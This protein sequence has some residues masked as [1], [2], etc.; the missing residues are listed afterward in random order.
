MSETSTP[1]RPRDKATLHGVHG[2]MV[3]NGRV[4]LT[5]DLPVSGRASQL[6]LRFRSSAGKKLLREA[7]AEASPCH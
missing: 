1:N 2:S 7:S 4:L 5:V 3:D 6:V